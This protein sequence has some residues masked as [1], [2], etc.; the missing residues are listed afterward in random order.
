MEDELL[1]RNNLNY[2]CFA[3]PKLS[4][5]LQNCG[6]EV[7]EDS[8]WDDAE[9][10]FEGPAPPKILRA[11]QGRLERMHYPRVFFGDQSEQRVQEFLE[12]LQSEKHRTNTKIR[13]VIARKGHWTSDWNCAMSSILLWIDVLLLFSALWVRMLRYVCRIQIYLEQLRNLSNGS[14]Q[15]TSLNLYDMLADSK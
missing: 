2:A 13:L 9:F 8:E 4:R 15:S 14:V 7:I 5:I 12:C 6:M 11:W 10:A 1:T 3:G